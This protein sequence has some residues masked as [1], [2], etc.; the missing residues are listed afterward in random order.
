MSIAINSLASVPASMVAAEV[1]GWSFTVRANVIE[2]PPGIVRSEN[3]LSTG[4]TYRELG[5]DYYQRHAPQHALKRKIRDL[6]AAGY[7][8]TAVPV[9]A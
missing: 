7:R 1:N 8:V 5:G 4:E 9:S 3:L 2:P 6:E